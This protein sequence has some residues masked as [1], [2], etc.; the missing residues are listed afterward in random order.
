VL[1]FLPESARLCSAHSDACLGPRASR[2]LAALGIPS[3][4]EAPGRPLPQSAI[5][6]GIAVE[7]SRGMMRGLV[8]VAPI[9]GRP[10]PTELPARRILTERFYSGRPDGQVTVRDGVAGAAKRPLEPRSVLFKHRE[11]GFARTGHGAECAHIA[12]AILADALGDEAYAMRTY[13][14]FS[15]RVV[16]Q[17]PERWTITRSRVLA[18]VNMIESEKSAGF[19][20]R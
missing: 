15:R 13:E 20:A 4:R 12:L 5:A 18:Y 3:Y 16:A 6:P 17:F 7:N 14:Y 11:K 19:G 8:A 1:R 2:A 10:L 9:C